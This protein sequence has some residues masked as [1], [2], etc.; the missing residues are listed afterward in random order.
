MLVFFG[1]VMPV[2]PDWA[3]ALVPMF[4][5]EVG[6]VISLFKEVHLLKAYIPISFMDEVSLISVIPLE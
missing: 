5:I 4:V 2:I 1:I 3:N 6:M